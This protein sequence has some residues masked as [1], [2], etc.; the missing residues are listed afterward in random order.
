MLF[1]KKKILCGWPVVL[2]QT[3]E[4]LL[5]LLVTGN[6]IRVFFVLQL[7]NQSSGVFAAQLVE[8]HLVHQ[9]VVVVRVDV[10]GFVQSSFGFHHHP[11]GQERA[12]LTIHEQRS[13]FTL[14]GQLLEREI[15][16]FGLVSA[17]K[18]KRVKK[19]C[20]LT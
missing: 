20:L 13:S 16:V 18:K 9:C 7:G 10:H 14:V 15:G 5:F 1:Y 19:C 12:N 6:E 17:L 2:A 3:F 8:H 11:L 4:I